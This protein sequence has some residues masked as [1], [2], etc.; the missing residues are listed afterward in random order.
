M[1]D[2]K[3]SKRVVLVAHCLL[4]Q[5]ARIDRYAFFP[6]AMGK[7]AQVLLDTDAKGAAFCSRCQRRLEAAGRL[8]EDGKL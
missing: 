8:A 1:F 7:A 3:R 6:G 5:N 4:N 2:D